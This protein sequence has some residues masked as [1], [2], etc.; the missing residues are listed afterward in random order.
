MKKA[1]RLLKKKLELAAIAVTYAEAGEW[2][3]AENWLDKIECLNRSRNPKFIVVALDRKFTEETAEYSVNL[4]ERMHYD[5]LA[6]NA[7]KP[8]NEKKLFGTGKTG[9]LKDNLRQLFDALIQRAQSSRIR[10]ETIVTMNDFRVLIK[11][12]LKRIRHVE[13]VLIQVSKD[14]QLSLN[15]GVPVYQIRTNET[16]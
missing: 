1:L 16:I 3:L 11:Q 15:L 14:Q 9:E 6:V 12:L 2:D 7:I 13:L 10:Y 8:S 4:A 5:L